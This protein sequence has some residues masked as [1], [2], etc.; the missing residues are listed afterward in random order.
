MKKYLKYL[1]YLIRHKWFVMIECF[2][3]GLYWQGIVH[4]MSKFLPNEF[5]PY[6]NYFQD[7]TT[8]FHE[9]GQDIKFDTAWLKHIHRNPHHWQYWVIEE[10]NGDTK[11]LPMKPK[12]RE[13]ML[14]DWAG[15]GKA[16]NNPDS[17]AQWYEKNKDKMKFHS[18]TEK[19]LQDKLKIN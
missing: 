16:Q 18:E 9:S 1:K 5:F 4:D 10:C 2:K 6:V 17:V 14:C 7:H 8:T 13:E 12:Y 19:W 11:I 3:I 15:A